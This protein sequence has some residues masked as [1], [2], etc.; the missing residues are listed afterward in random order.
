MSTCKILW[1][2]SVVYN[3]VLCQSSP[4]LLLVIHGGFPRAL[5]TTHRVATST[6]CAHV[7]ALTGGSTHAG[8]GP[9]CHPS[10]SCHRPPSCLCHLFWKE[11]VLCTH[12]RNTGWHEEKKQLA[13]WNLCHID[14]VPFCLDIPWTRMRGDACLCEQNPTLAVY[15]FPMKKV[16]LCCFTTVAQNP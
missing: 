15:F 11:F 2:T 5:H 4:K 8:G 9:H 14:P 12:N 13:I 6:H 3:S 1:E 10:G 16:A 7:P